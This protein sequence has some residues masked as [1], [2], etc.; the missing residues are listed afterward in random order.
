[1]KISI[2]WEK[3]DLTPAFLYR[4]IKTSLVLCLVISIFALFYLGPR[5]ALQ[6]FFFALIGTANFWLLSQIGLVL[7]LRRHNKQAII[8][9]MIKF[10]LLYT[11][12]LLFCHHL[13]IEVSS[14]LLGFNTIF[15][16]IFLKIM[17]QLLNLWLNSEENRT[18]SLWNTRKKS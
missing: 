9:A 17:G 6:Y 16:V 4:A 1:M 18:G 5:W 11:A 7:L 12:L 2:N 10:P 15:L 3:L 14:F 8:M 13:G